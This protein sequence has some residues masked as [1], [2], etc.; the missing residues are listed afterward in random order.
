MQGSGVWLVKEKHILFISLPEYDIYKRGDK[1]MKN[2]NVFTGMILSVPLMV[3]MK[4][5]FENTTFLKPL[6]VLMGTKARENQ[7]SK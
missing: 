2:K 1:E 4:I 5:I 3:I 7:V 6:A